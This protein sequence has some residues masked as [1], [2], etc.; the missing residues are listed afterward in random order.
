MTLFSFPVQSLVARRS[1][2][3]ARYGRYYKPLAREFGGE[4]EIRRKEKIRK[5]KADESC[6]RT[7]EQQGS[8][9]ASRRWAFSETDGR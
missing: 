8:A 5:K 3:C 1:I 4:G 6:P 7:Y 2:T 9:L